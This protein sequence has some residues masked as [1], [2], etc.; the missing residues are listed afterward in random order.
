QLLVFVEEVL[1]GGGSLKFTLERL[2]QPARRPVVRV[3]LTD[4]RE[5][6]YGPLPGD[7]ANAPVYAV[8]VADVPLDVRCHIRQGRVGCHAGTSPSTRTR[9]VCRLVRIASASATIASSSASAYWQDCASAAAGAL[10]SSWGQ[11]A[12]HSSYAASPSSSGRS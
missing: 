8:G 11:S 6:R 7:Q 1:P 12:S 10:T 4:D 9:F 5:E 3:E 2:S